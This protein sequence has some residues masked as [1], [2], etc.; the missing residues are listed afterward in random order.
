MDRV[1][2]PLAR[3][4]WTLRTLTGRD[5]QLAD[6]G[7]GA[8]RALLA[9]LL[10]N[11]G[12]QP[13]IDASRLTA[14]E[15]DRLFAA[16]WR[17]TFGDTILA[18]H[19]CEQCRELFDL[20]LSLDA[21]LNSLDATPKPDEVVGLTDEGHARLADG[22][23]VRPPV[24]ADEAAV[25]G[26]PVAEAAQVLARRCVNGAVI[27]DADVLDR[28][29][30][31]LDPVIDLDLIGVCPECGCRQAIRFSI[32]HYLLTA[33]RRDRRRL[34]REI[35]LIAS[36]YGWS[37]DEILSLDRQ[38]RQALA[39]HIEADRSGTRGVAWA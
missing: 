23:T 2:V 9:R 31:W 29:L 17:H 19:R 12:S 38:E 4:S 7:A 13:S 30:D 16:L 21:L 24:A 1:I 28:V 37:L 26:L 20:T 36:A 32:E 14:A 15:R 10:E 27:P 3:G 8:G 25:A 6:G 18:S 33:L 22:Q 39:T 35:H 34:M 5:E 11:G